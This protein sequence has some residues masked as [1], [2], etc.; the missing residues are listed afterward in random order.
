[1]PA[2]TETP[3]PYTPTPIPPSPTPEPTYVTGVELEMPDD[4]FSPGEEVYLMAYIMSGEPA[5]MTNVPFVCVLDVGVGVYW[6]YPGWEPYPP[7][8]DYESITLTPGM[9]TKSVL[10]TFTWPETGNDT[11]TGAIFLSAMLNEDMT[12]LFGTMGMVEFGWG[13]N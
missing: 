11:F 9:E 8:F 5:V 3:F 6:F 13:P 1:T 7:T 2:P 12:D 10:G 4:F